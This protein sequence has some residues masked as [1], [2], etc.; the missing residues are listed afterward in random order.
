MR[1]RDENIEECVNTISFICS[2]H[3]SPK[4][5][6]NYP[7]NERKMIWQGRHANDASQVRFTFVKKFWG[8]IGKSKVSRTTRNQVLVKLCRYM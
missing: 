8:K 4:Q 7:E 5:L 2:H 1:L 6:K 3:F